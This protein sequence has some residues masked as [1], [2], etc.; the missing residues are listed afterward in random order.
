L[1]SAK[2]N[3]ALK[4]ATLQVVNALLVKQLHFRILLRRQLKI[5]N[6]ILQRKANAIAAGRFFI[7]ERGGGLES[8]NEKVIYTHFRYFTAT[9]GYDACRVGRREAHIIEKDFRRTGTL[10]NR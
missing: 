8:G 10:E 6:I 1:Q 5:K 4:A 2:H 7:C 3:G 9:P